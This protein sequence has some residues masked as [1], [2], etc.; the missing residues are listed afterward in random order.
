VNFFDYIREWF[1]WATSVF[2]LAAMEAYSWPLVGNW[3]GDTFNNLSTFTSR[4]A[5]ELWDASN[6]YEEISGKVG[7][8]LSWDTIWSYILSYVPNLEALSGWFY[9]WW[10]NVSAVI[11]NWWA[12][13]QTAVQGWISAAVQPFNSMLTA[14]SNFWNSLW[15]QLLSSFYSLQSSWNNFWLVTFPNLVNFSWLT[16][17]WN[18]KLLEV[19]S[20]IDSTIKSHFPFYDDLIKLWGS[21]VEFFTSPLQYLWERFTDWFFGVK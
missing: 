15:P 13:M 1:I 12:S 8:Y 2:V 4:V 20:L 21:I 7:D 3:L 5:G 10:G 9:S 18:S 14:W 17:W 11:A 6:W 19:N 16:T